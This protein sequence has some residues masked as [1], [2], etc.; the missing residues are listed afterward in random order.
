[1]GIRDFFLGDIQ[2]TVN[3]AVETAVSRSVQPPSREAQ[4]VS[5]EA[6][7]KLVPVS[8]CLSVLET[9]MVQI[10]IEVFRGIEMIDSPSW[11][12]TP[13]VNNNV[14]QAE[15]VKDTVL[16]LAVHGNA[17]WYITKGPRGIANLEVI[18]NKS[19]SVSTD[20]FGNVTYAI[21]N[22][23]VASENIKH[24][25]MWSLPGEVM[26]EGPLQ[27][28]KATLKAAW[29]LNNYFANWF[30]NSAVPTG[31][32]N[33]DSHINQEQAQTLLEAF[34][35][36]QKTRTPAV[37]GYGM[38]YEG[39]TLDPEQAQFLENQ[40]FMARQIALMFGIPSQYLS[41][42]IESSGMAYTNTNGDR[43]KLF[44]DGLQQYITRIEQALTDLLPRGQYAKFNLTTFL[45]PDNKT[46]YE[47]YAIALASKFMTVNEVRE[48]EGMPSLPG[49][50]KVAE[51]VQPAQPNNNQ[52]AQNDTGNQTV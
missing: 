9:S 51:P 30:D 13:D 1:M 48:L 41:L 50:D 36:S 19:I 6:A 25:K 32:L 2:N 35:E 22:K 16:S 8:R 40:K 27:R 14:S 24:L 34:L 37:M 38:S 33:T 3:Q 42:S 45:R 12:V 49:G 47:G 39:L 10:P 26:G 18:P 7:L 17:F 31:I 29:D 20:R 21:N 28:H 15:F 52:G 11:L 44:E 43:Q 23:K 5:P 4:V 46:R